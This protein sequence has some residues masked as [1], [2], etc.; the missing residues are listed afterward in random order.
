MFRIYELESDI[1]ANMLHHLLFITW[2]P[3]PGIHIFG[4]Y[5]VK[6]YGIMWGTALMCCFFLGTYIFRKSGKDEEKVTEI[7]QYIFIFGLIGSRLAHVFFYGFDYYM[8]HPIEIPE[9]WKGGLASHGGVVGGLIGLYVFCRRNKELDFFWTLDHGII[10]V[11]QLAA[12]I[13][14]GNLM[15]SELYGKP[16]QMPWGFIF[17]QVDNIPRHPVVLYECISY[18][19]I[20]FFMLYLFNKYRDSKPGIYLVVFLILVFGT[21]FLLEFCKDPEGYLIWG[22]ISKTQLLDLPFVIAGAVLY[23]FMAKGKL[24]YKQ[25]LNG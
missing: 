14:F 10:V 2:D 1:C 18:L 5:S 9:V 12:L 21:R 23:Y 13:R 7:V 25:A 3:A 17:V 19:L 4:D 20:Q 15:N 6:W 8:A 22:L 16:T 24:H 11:V